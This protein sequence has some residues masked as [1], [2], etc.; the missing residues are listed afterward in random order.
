M[1]AESASEVYCPPI[2]LSSLR[3][4]N[5]GAAV[6]DCAENPGWA[7]RSSP[8]LGQHF[9]GE[10]SQSLLSMGATGALEAQV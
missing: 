3:F 2:W 6:H 7:L 1:R 8:S 10:S 5:M 4:S 9:F